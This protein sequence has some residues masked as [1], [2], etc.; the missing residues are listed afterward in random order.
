M[1]FPRWPSLNFTVGVSVGFFIGRWFVA[2]Y[3]PLDAGADPFRPPDVSVLVG[4]LHCGQEYDSYQIEWRIERDAD[5][6]PHGFWCCPIA[7]CDGRGFGFDIFPVDPDYRDERGGWITDDDEEEDIDGEGEP[8]AQ[9]EPQAPEAPP[10][11]D[12][13][14]PW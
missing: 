6:R 9:I 5:G 11:D 7:G 3:D 10:A 12:E 8:S 2:R 14:L 4:C 13:A 1:R